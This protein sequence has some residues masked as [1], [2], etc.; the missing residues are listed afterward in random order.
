MK[1]PECGNFFSPDQQAPVCPHELL[2][3]FEPSPRLLAEKERL[4]MDE[5]FHSKDAGALRHW[6]ESSNPAVRDYAESLL[7]RLLQGTKA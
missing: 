6:R 7:D 2:N 1:C 4:A 3:R 5:A